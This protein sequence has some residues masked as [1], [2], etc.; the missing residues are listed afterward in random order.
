MK[1][2]KLHILL[3]IILVI[4]VVV[5]AVLMCN[6]MND[7]IIGVASAQDP[8]QSGKDL[9]DFVIKTEDGYTW[10]LYKAQNMIYEVDGIFLDNKVNPNDVAI[11]MLERIK[12]ELKADGYI[13]DEYISQNTV[14]YDKYNLK[15]ELT[16]VR[17][18]HLTSAS[19]KTKF[20]T[21]HNY[22][23][24]IGGADYS[25]NIAK[26]GGIAVSEGLE[27]RLDNDAWLSAE[28][29]KVGSSLCF[30][31]DIPVGNYQ[32][33]YVVSERFV[34]DG[35]ERVAY[36]YPPTDELPIE[37]V[38]E[39]ATLQVPE[40]GA[41]ATYG[42][43]A[44]DIAVSVS[45][46]SFP[47]GTWALCDEQN[48][49]AFDGVDDAGNHILEVGVYTLYFDFT[50]FSANYSGLKDV[51][52]NV[53]IAPK[54]VNLYIGDVVTLVGD[55]LKDI[56]DVPYNFD[57]NQL[58]P[59]DS[60]QD[61]NLELYYGEINTNKTGTYNIFARIRN[62]N[63]SLNVG[64]LNSMFVDQGRYF[65]FD[66]KMTISAEDGMTFNVYLVG[67]FQN[68]TVRVEKTESFYGI[69]KDYS[70]NGEASPAWHAGLDTPF[71]PATRAAYK[72]IFEDKYGNV[73]AVPNEYI[74]EWDTVPINTAYV[75]IK[76]DHH[77]YS[78]ETI[79]SLTLTNGQDTIEFGRHNIIII[80]PTPNR[81]DS[82]NPLELAATV[83]GIIGGLLLL[84]ATLIGVKM[85]T[86][87]NVANNYKNDF[88]VR[89]EIVKTVDCENKQV[90][91]PVQKDAPKKARHGKKNKQQRANNSQNKIEQ[92]DESNER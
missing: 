31:K 2:S 91:K 59:C 72:F 81:P 85:W 76:D 37:C 50:P 92:K 17:N 6:F 64:N 55:P 42:T 54:Q 68:I 86:T 46:L 40:V 58:A 79:T 53:T 66:G 41:S 44:K 34:F 14:F 89:E 36:H 90:N 23:I 84:G 61:L 8:V 30:G 43:F 10:Q 71:D 16:P 57:V 56:A 13:D 35:I 47:N 73:I 39:S 69:Y 3:A 4:V 29:E 67:G 22:E 83:L 77:L 27:Y 32:V 26:S 65:V 15:F 78:L 75:V 74:V 25:L 5:A 19:N 38:I 62:S 28:T 60:I 87:N 70:S 45:D 88:Y 20:T 21:V 11:L 24:M 82:Q 1:T 12:Q 63:Y 33:R 18:A 51:A 7:A 9:N 52:V 48:D 49:V 80:N